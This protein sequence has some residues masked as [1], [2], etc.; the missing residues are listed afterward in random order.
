MAF[1]QVLF[2]A[3]LIAFGTVAF[4]QPIP[5]ILEPAYLDT[6]PAGTTNTTLLVLT[7]VT[8]SCRYSSSSSDFT[9]M[10]D[11]SYTGHDDDISNTTL[12]GLRDGQNYIYFVRCQDQ[13][14]ILDEGAPDGGFYNATFSIST[15]NITSPPV[16]YNIT[17]NA[18]ARNATISWMTDKNTTSMILYGTGLIPDNSTALN[19]TMDTVHSQFLTGLL[20]QTEYHFIIQATDSNNV[21]ANESGD[22]FFT[23]IERF[24][25]ISSFM[26][27]LASRNLSFSILEGAN[28]MVGDLAD[29]DVLHSLLLKSGA[30]T[31]DIADF[32]ISTANLSANIAVNSNVN[33]SNFTGMFS[34]GGGVF[35]QAAWLDIANLTGSYN[36]RA[37]IPPSSGIFLYINGTPNAPAATRVRT[38]CA[39]PGDTLCYTLDSSQITVRLPSFSGL[40]IGNDTQAPAV[41]VSSPLLQGYNTGNIALSYIATDNTFLASC[42]YTINSALINLPTCSN[43]TLHL[44]DGHYVLNVY[45]NDTAGNIGNS[46][47]VFD[48]HLPVANIPSTSGGS[49]AGAAPPIKPKNVF[50]FYAN[51][52]LSL[53]VTNS[54]TALTRIDVLTSGPMDSSMQITLASTPT[55][56]PGK[57]YQTIFIDPSNFTSSFL[58]AAI[59]FSVPR[60]WLAANSVNESSIRLFHFGSS[61]EQLKTDVSNSGP[62]SVTYSATTASMSPFAIAAITEAPSAPACANI[63][64]TATNGTDCRTFPTPCDVPAGWKNVSACPASNTTPQSPA[65]AMEAAKS[66]STW[67]LL[68]AVLVILAIGIIAALKRHPRPKKSEEAASTPVNGPQ[69]AA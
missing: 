46:T 52:F 33:S 66:D 16:V 62:D 63:S 8:A 24:L 50:P 31:L 48:V 28:T 35:D 51:G 47:V 64:T 56:P 42:W 30:I 68:A 44:P 3:L 53:D 25:N 60:S 26:S 2:V 58:Q 69:P 6:L 13:S 15:A 55:S 39:G 29:T 45:A 61:W 34:A 12:I 18:S 4:A 36:A 27:H 54:S 7:D 37:M 43:D 11:F 14:G 5:I 9:Q 23:G 41:N 40:A 49:G 21:T 22:P 17:V 57:I 10:T 65:T 19:G 67:L 1:K 38:Q 20:P 59:Y 32:N